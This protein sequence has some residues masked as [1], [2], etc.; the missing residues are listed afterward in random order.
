MERVGLTPQDAPA[1][2]TRVPV[3]ARQKPGAGKQTPSTPR[4]T[5]DPR[6]APEDSGS[7]PPKPLAGSAPQPYRRPIS[8]PPD[9]S[10]ADALQSDTTPWPFH[11]FRRPPPACAV[12]GTAP[13]PAHKS[14]QKCRAGPLPRHKP[15]T[16]VR[17]GRDVMHRWCRHA[18]AA[19]QSPPPNF[20]LEPPNPETPSAASP[21]FP[22]RSF[23]PPS[24]AYQRIRPPPHRR[25]TPP[26]PRQSPAQNGSSSNPP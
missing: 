26:S 8:I 19:A 15:P 25:T 14:P 3:P 23:R 1:P 9:S 13:P 18:D 10:P 12:G 22:V 24:P 17:P 16:S 21:E 7:S 2:L 11:R 20:P 4:Q 6:R 5:I